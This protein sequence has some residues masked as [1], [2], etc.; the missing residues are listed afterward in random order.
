MKK[1]SQYGLAVLVVFAVAAYRGSARDAEAQSKSAAELQ[2]EIALSNPYPNDLGPATLSKSV[3]DGYP[4]D[5][6]EGYHLMLGDAAHPRCQTCHTAARPLNS[7][8]VEPEGKDMDEREANVEKLKQ[9]QP[10][11]FGPKADGIWEV[12]ADQWQR[13]VRRM[14]SKPGC[15]ISVPDAKKIWAF[16]VYDGM[17]R[18]VGAH[19]AAWKAHREKLIARFKAKYP[20]RYEMLKEQDDL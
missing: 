13:Y 20:K 19:A 7:R 12:S 1:W 16:L 11:L 15:D 8:F 10:G 5:I 3:L 4:K 17:H 6:Q 18:K 14:L 9:E 2:R